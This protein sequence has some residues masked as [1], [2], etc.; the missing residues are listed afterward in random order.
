M[1]FNNYGFW[2][3]EIFYYCKGKTVT[4]ETKTINIEASEYNIAYL[5]A[6]LPVLLFLSYMWKISKKDSPTL[7]LLERILFDYNKLPENVFP[8]PL[9]SKIELN[10]QYKGFE[11]SAQRMVSL[12]LRNRHKAYK[13]S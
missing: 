10:T 13:G 8:F 1:E 12:L 7:V 6:T 11:H 2:T 3:L 4:E 9:A 5:A